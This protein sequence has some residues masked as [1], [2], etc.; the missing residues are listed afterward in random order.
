MIIYIIGL[1]FTVLVGF[2]AGAHFVY[3]RTKYLLEDE[4]TTSSKLAVVVLQLTTKLKTVQEQNELLT[5]QGSKE[6]FNA[7]QAKTTDRSH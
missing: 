2:I 5:E 6:L 4:I 7:R 3:K 1:V